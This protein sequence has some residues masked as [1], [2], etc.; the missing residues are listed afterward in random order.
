MM[1]SLGLSLI[2]AFL[3]TVLSQAQVDFTADIT[4]GC[5]PIKVKFTIDPATIDYDTV[6]SMLWSFGFLTDIDS[7]VA[8]PD[9]VIYR[10]P[11]EFTVSLT[12]NN[13]SFKVEKVNYIT[14]H[15]TVNASFSWEEYAPNYNYRFVPNDEIAPTDELYTFIWE[16]YELSGSDDRVSIESDINSQNQL[17]A[18]DSITLDTGTYRVTLTV[19][20][21]DY[22]CLTQSVRRVV[23][24]D[25]I[26]LP[27][28]FIYGAGNYF[29][30]DPEDRNTVLNFQL[31]NRNG[32]KVFEQTAPIINWNGETTWGKALNTGVYYYVLEAT[33]GDAQGRF[34]KNG[35]I[36]LYPEK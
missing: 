4:E 7:T 6:E 23:I 29:I 10:N 12:I 9:T 25:E 30:I 1:R 32:M 20:N 17:R 24:V 33:E 36:H 26:T 31:F 34:T 18:I 19:M 28:V 27:N 22:G 2:L 35:F 8:N 5:S 13:R 16:Y 3:V 14:V 11:G 15:Q 21:Q